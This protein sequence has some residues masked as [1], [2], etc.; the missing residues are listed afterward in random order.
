MSEF[1]TVIK[2]EY[3]SDT[4]EFCD[5]VGI[6]LSQ[7]GRIRIKIES[8]WKGKTAEAHDSSTMGLSPKEAITL[9]KHLITL[10][11]EEIK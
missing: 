3:K 2:T 1:K 10:A 7:S 9:A 4:L 11:T 6:R 5:T 8:D